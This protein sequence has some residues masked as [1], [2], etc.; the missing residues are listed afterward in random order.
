MSASIAPAAL[1]Q[2]SQPDLPS[3]APR[4]LRVAVAVLSVLLA[5]AVVAGF[6]LAQRAAAQ[7]DAQAAMLRDTTVTQ[8]YQALERQSVLP[9][10][11]RSVEAL[12]WAIATPQ[13]DTT[14]A[15]WSNE[16]LSSRLDGPILTARVA[17]SWTAAPGEPAASYLEF[18]AEVAPAAAS[19]ESDSVM[20]CVVRSGSTSA[21]LA[22]SRVVLTPGGLSMDPCPAAVL[23]QAGI[24][25]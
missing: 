10:G 18:I 22:T 17:T 13:S 2:T 9:P 3:A 11:Q 8:T 21:P 23:R 24:T 5:G 20:T 15:L 7:S 25:S 19:N 14:G 6:V 12:E 16:V 1:E 4:R